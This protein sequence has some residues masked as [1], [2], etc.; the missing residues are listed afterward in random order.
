MKQNIQGLSREEKDELLTRLNSES[1][2]IQRSFAELVGCTKLY[3][4]KHGIEPEDLKLF[5]TQ[6]NMYECVDTIKSNDTL[7]DIMMKVARGEYWSFFNYQLLEHLIKC[8]SKNNEDKSIVANLNSYI[9]KFKLYCERR[10]SEVPIGVVASEKGDRKFH[11]K[12]KMDKIFRIDSQLAFFQKMQYK[13]GQILERQLLLVDV[14][15][16]CIE[17][18]FRYLDSKSMVF[19]ITGKQKFELSNIG[20]Q[21]LYY[22][23]HEIQMTQTT[24]GRSSKYFKLAVTLI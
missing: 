5:F 6:C 13:I 22:G 19:S 2:T 21:W 9:A 15:D 23:E 14:F 8:Y 16:G 12:V 4:R 11:F 3:L 20:V 10:L 7:A 1:E 18:A 17:L 24:E